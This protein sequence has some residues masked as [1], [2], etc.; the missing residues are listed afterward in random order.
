MQTSFTKKNNG[1]NHP[2]TIKNFQ[3]FPHPLQVYDADF[4]IAFNLEKQEILCYLLEA[5]YWFRS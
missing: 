3:I 1:N 5:N 4:N 2:L